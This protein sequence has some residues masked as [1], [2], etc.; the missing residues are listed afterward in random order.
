MSG[1]LFYSR[2]RK[3]KP[4]AEETWASTASATA[5]AADVS[6]RRDEMENCG[7]LGGA[8]RTLLLRPAGGQLILYMKFEFFQASLFDQVILGKPGFLEQRFQLLRIVTMLLFKA[9]NLFTI[10]LTVRFQIHG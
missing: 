8:E 9:A 7:A 1:S 5:P 4:K 6:G 3:R 10:R 2:A